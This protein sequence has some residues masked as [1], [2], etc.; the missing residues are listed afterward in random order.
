MQTK[1]PVIMI[2]PEDP[3]PAHGLIYD[4]SMIH[5]AIRCVAN[6]RMINRLATIVSPAVFGVS[7]NMTFEV[8]P[9]SAA[10]MEAPKVQS[11]RS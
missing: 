6:L 7:G 9:G 3:Q 4:P 8:N 2:R 1:E 5:G 11:I 10:G